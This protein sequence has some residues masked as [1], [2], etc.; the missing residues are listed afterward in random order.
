[1][2][3]AGDG[4]ELELEGDFGKHFELHVPAGYERD[5]LYVLTPDVMQVLIDEAA[6]RRVEIVDD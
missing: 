5:A 1:M 3:Y 2:F 6:D 4:P